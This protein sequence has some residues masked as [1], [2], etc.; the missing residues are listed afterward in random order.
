MAETG[1]ARWP[2][3]ILDFVWHGSTSN[4]VGRMGFCSVRSYL[5]G[6]RFRNSLPQT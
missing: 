4:D 6:R 3:E 1:V 5:F 2:T